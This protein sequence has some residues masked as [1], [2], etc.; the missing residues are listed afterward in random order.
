M[1]NIE[2]ITGLLAGA[3]GEDKV[4]RDVS[5]L[6]CFTGGHSTAGMLNLPG[7]VCRP[8]TIEDVVEI[9]KIANEHKI[10]TTAVSSGTLDYT[11]HPFEGGLVID[12]SWMNRILEINEQ[13]DYAVIEPGVTIGQ[14]NTAI[15]EKGY[16]AP[17]GSYPPS[18][19]VLGNYTERG[20]VSM[21][22]CGIYD[23]VLGLEVVTPTGIVFRTGS[24]AF[25]NGEWHTSWGPFP[26]IRGLFMGA[27]GSFGVFTK[28]AVRIY[29]MNET[30]KMVLAGFDDI[31][32]SMDYCVRLARAGLVEHNIIWHWAMYTM[33]ESMY[34]Y[35][36]LPSPRLLALKPWEKPQN[37]HYNIVTAQMSGYEEDME[38]HEKLCERLAGECGGEHIP[39]EKAGE[40]MPGAWEHWKV[41][42]IDRWPCTK[43]GKGF[44]QFGAFAFVYAAPEKIADMEKAAIKKFYDAD[45][46]F[47]MTYY[48]QTFDRGRSQSIRFT[49]FINPLDKEKVQKA[50]LTI[51]EFYKWAMEKYGAVAMLVT[52]PEQ[53][54]LLPMTGGYYDVWKLLKQALDPNNIMNPHTLY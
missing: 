28:G 24:A 38:L 54:D 2:K 32:K 52:H 40:E 1:E 39:R 3:I 13:C 46:R 9:M 15:R 50:L 36:Q 27:G 20:H 4:T 41:I 18:I 47:G 42:G 6:A 51:D 22:S 44:V 12:F 7:A 29:P 31:N 16:W 11:T 25:E 45:M 37:C 14:L 8:S 34:G 26:D 5:E 23:D 21:R 48:S 30:R 10:P 17:F 19:C 35:K 53:R 43:F 49:P 33:F